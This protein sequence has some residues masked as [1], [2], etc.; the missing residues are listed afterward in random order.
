MWYMNK[1]FINIDNTVELIL[2]QNNCVEVFH[3]IELVW[4]R[5]GLILILIEGEGEGKGL[6][7]VVLSLQQKIPARR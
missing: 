3:F 1:Y 5:D 6:K 7:L 4:R 2:P